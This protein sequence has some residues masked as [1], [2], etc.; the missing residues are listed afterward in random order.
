MRE[1]A[2]HTGREGSTLHTWNAKDAFMSVLVVRVLLMNKG[3]QNSLTEKSSEQL[4]F[5][6]SSKG[7]SS[8]H[9]HLFQFDH[10]SW[11]GLQSLSVWVCS[12]Q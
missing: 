1:A 10:F 7:S 5:F 4:C 8:P 12:T 11:A 3:K 6:R 2:E 9:T